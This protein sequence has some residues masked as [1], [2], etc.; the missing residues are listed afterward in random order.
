MVVCWLVVWIIKPVGVDAR[1]DKEQPWSLG[2]P[3]AKTAKSEYDCSFI[4]LHHLDAAPDRDGEGDED[5]DVGEEGDEG[6]TDPTLL[7]TKVSPL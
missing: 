6:R 1:K 7:H 3:R 5:Q 4:L 2:S